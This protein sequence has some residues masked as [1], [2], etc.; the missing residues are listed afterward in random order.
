VKRVPGISMVDWN[1]DFVA[2]LHGVLV[3]K[4]REILISDEMYP[5]MSESCAERLHDIRVIARRSGLLDNLVVKMS[6]LVY[7]VFPWVGTCQLYTLHYALLQRGIKSRIPWRT[8]VYLEAHFKGSEGE[9]EGIIR[10]IVS[11]DLN[12]FTLPLPENIQIA[13]KYNEYVPQ[14]LLRK[15]FIKDFLDFEGLR[16]SMLSS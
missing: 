4:I 6:E 1:V 8:S 5:Y 2:E 3:R 14:P 7:A 9:L 13:Y 12:L 16:E 15:Q 10:D 11:S